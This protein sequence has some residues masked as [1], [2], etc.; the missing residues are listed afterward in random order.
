MFA[1]IAAAANPA[2]RAS[3]VVLAESS[4]ATH[5]TSDTSLVMLA[6]SGA[7]AQ[8][9]IMAKL[10]M[11]AESEAVAQST[12]MAPL[13]M[14]AKRGPATRSALIGQLP[15]CTSFPN[16]PLHRVWRWRR[17]HFCNNC[18]H[19]TNSNGRATQVAAHN[20]RRCLLKNVLLY[21]SSRMRNK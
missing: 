9:T 15:M 17:R 14:L 10:V 3:F 8:S 20:C 7:V 5:S 13:V 21:T 18:F 16:A 12:I 6:E 4:A 1:N 19:A 11:L 2:V